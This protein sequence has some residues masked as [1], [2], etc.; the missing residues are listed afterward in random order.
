M[1]EFRPFTAIPLYSWEAPYE[2]YEYQ[3][4]KIPG[5]YN[6]RFRMIKPNGWS[7]SLPTDKFP[8]IIFFHGSGENG[9]ADPDL[10]NNS[11]QLQHGGQ[12]HM[13]AVLNGTFPGFVIYPQMRRTGT[14][15]G[16]ADSYANCPNNNWNPEWREAVRYVVDKLI[17]DYKVDPNRIYVHGL[18]G[19]GEASWQFITDYPEYIA[20]GHPMSAAGDE[21]HTQVYSGY[22]EY[23]KHIPLW[24]SQGALDTN[25]TPE[26]GNSQVTAIRNIGGSIRYS[27]YPTLGHGTWNSEYAKPDFFSWFLSKKKNQISVFYEQPLTCPG[28]PVSVRIGFT[29]T[30]YPNGRGNTLGTGNYGFG[31]VGNRMAITNYEWA[32]GNTNT[33]VATGAALNE[34]TITTAGPY[35]PGTYYGR[36]QRTDGTWTEW[37]DPVV[38]DNSRGPSSIPA[39]TANGKSINLPSLDGSADVILSGPIGKAAYQWKKGGANVS[40]ATDLNFTASVADSYTLIAK[41]A[42][43]NPYQFDAVPTEY[44]PSTTGCFSTDS[45]PISITTSNGLGVPSPPGNFFVSP[46]SQTNILV[47]W[48]D[49]SNNETGFE[50]Y[51]STSVG[52]GYSLVTI[53]PGGASS[54]P[55]IYSDVNIQANTT[56]YY[57]V[58]AVNTSGGSAY[59]SVSSAR[60]TVDTSSPTAPVLTIGGTLRTTALLQWTGATDNVAITAYDIYQN[61]SL[62]ASVNGN[63]TY[64]AANNLGA[65]S[66]YNFVVKARDLAGNESPP[67]N[68]VATIARNSGL[69]YK[70]YIHNNFSTSGEIASNGTLTKIGFISSFSVSQRTQSDKYAFIYEGF[71]NIPTT[72]DY[73]F[74]LQTDEGSKMWIN[75]VLVV[76]HDGQ[77]T[78]TKKASSVINLSAGWYPIRVDYF[79]NAGAECLTVRWTRPGQSEQTIPSSAFTETAASLPAVSNPSNLLSTSIA[80]N[81]VTLGWNDNSS[82]ETG[83]EIYRL[84]S[85]D[86][87]G[88]Y[89][90]V[91]SVPSATTSWIDNNVEANTRYY[92]RVR[93]ISE[94]NASSLVNLNS[95]G[96]V[97]TSAAPTPPVMPT[98]LSASVFSTTQIDLTW[99]DVTS[100]AGYEI[101]KSYNSTNGFV[102][103]ATVSANISSYSDVQANGNSTAYYQVRSLGAGGT[104]SAYSEIASAS[105]T[106]RSPVFVAIPDQTL[107]QNNASAQIINITVSDPD[108]DPISF[109]FTGLPSSNS[110]TSNGYGKGTLSLTSVLPGTYNIQVQA[111]DGIATVT[112]NFVLTVNSNRAPNIS[113][114]TIDGTAV[115]PTPITT[116]QNQSTEAGRKLTMV[117]TILDP[118][119]NAQLT[120]APLVTNLPSFATTVW[121]GTGTANRTF[122]VTFNTTAANVGIYD[123]LSITFRDNSG[124]I[125]VQTFSLVVTPFDPHYTVALNFIIATTDNEV[126]PWNNTPL[127]PATAVNMINLKDELGNTVKY[128]KFNIPGNWSTP[129]KRAILP[130]DPLSI[131][132]KKVR[133]SYYIKNTGSGGADSRTFK[134]TNLNPALKYKVTGYSAIPGTVGNTRYARFTITG[135]E[136]PAGPDVAQILPDLNV[137]N[138]TSATRTSDFRYPTTAG[139]LLV[140]VRG[141]QANSFF[142]I[143]ALILE[144]SYIEQSPPNTPSNVALQAPLNNKVNITWQDNSL[145]ETNFKIYRALTAAG[146]YTEVA[147]VGENTTGY[148]DVTTIGR[149]T[150]YY[151][152][153]AFNT[154]GESALS[155]SA[156]ITTPNGTPVLANPGTVILNVGQVVQTN[157]SATDPEGDPISFSVLNLPSFATLVDNGNGTG[158]IQF[159]AGLSNVGPYI[160]TLKVNDSYTA[161]AEAEFSLV[162]ADPEINEAVYI[163]FVSTSTVNAAAPWNNKSLTSDGALVNNVGVASPMIFA[164]SATANWASADN[165][166]VTTGTNAAIYPDRVLQS[167]WTTS[168]TVNTTNTITLSGLDNAKRYNITILGSRNEFWFANTIYRVNTGVPSGAEITLNTRKNSSALARFVGIQPSS[169]TIVISVRKDP[170]NYNPSPV[171]PA[172]D[173]FNRDGSINAMVVEA[174]TPVVPRRPSSLVAGGLSKSSIRLTWND[175]SSNETG[176]EVQ[177]AND[178][179]GPFATITTLAANITTWDDIGLPQ[180]KAYAYR[181]RSIKTSAPAAQSEYTNAAITST[182]DKIVLI[183]INS[184]TIE[185]HP[186]ETSGLWNNLNTSPGSMNTA[187]GYTWYNFIENTPAPTPIGMHEIYYGNGGSTV[188]GYVGT[189]PIYPSEVI[190]PAFLFLPND[191]PSEWV[192]QHLDPNSAYDMLFFSSDWDRTREG[193]KIV[194]DFTVGGSSQSLFN[195]R[196][197]SERVFFYGV[198]PEQD[199]TIYFQV[200][201]NTSEVIYNGLW[202]AFEIRSFTPLSAAFDNIAP[203]TPLNLTASNVASDSLRLTWTASSDNLGVTGYEIFRDGSLVSTVATTTARITGL[204]ASTTYNFTVRARD[205]KGNRSAFSNILPV[206]TSGGSGARQAGEIATNE[207]A[208]KDEYAD[209]DKAVQLYPNP[210]SGKLHILIPSELHSENSVVVYLINA[211]GQQVGKVTKTLENNVVEMNVHDLQSGLYNVMI[212]LTSGKIQKRFVKE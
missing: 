154:Y 13:N 44:R 70:Y 115:T 30:I 191:P 1:P 209:L 52:S 156:L 125:N 196:N 10:Q 37:S 174:Y 38:I 107:F 22:K 93:A 21:F 119:G 193:N 184:T 16:P 57:R 211:Q 171:A 65:L 74:S 12:T 41:D 82:N 8:L 15:C 135:K 116:V 142:Y 152:V 79:E 91:A 194:T 180:N 117:F 89:Q 144:A 114:L 182:F 56:Y 151:K 3:N 106:N 208:Q 148:S 173:I 204:H 58:R 161:S 195:G 109:Q 33:V 137:I 201:A 83:F 98:P 127:K 35:T 149:K 87:T 178:P 24:S 162:V 165:V 51:R 146:P 179:A 92:Y 42:A 159:N 47:N 124:G 99:A 122:T 121:A 97:V 168:Q 54:N 6:L 104:A 185:G 85:A 80:Y 43:G 48:D 187:E 96:Y 9:G 78:C 145:N 77:H 210:V 197:N 158:Y 34:I 90:V 108:I 172:I 143:N 11:R 110:F 69:L 53:V 118:N 102:T 164:H 147:T 72:G 177:R 101:Q 50:I 190:R 4:P 198:R 19:G 123:D 129:P 49:R 105:T 140:N 5:I 133:E 86:G 94:S 76:D 23:Y 169:G 71:I 63:A 39:I 212:P 60:T 153:S 73:T 141:T 67:S 167:G 157:I 150:Y 111:S 176:F 81:Q 46:V 36:F 7:S 131:Y 61:G 138:N 163:N 170:T 186:Q 27:Y 207:T 88:T 95:P 20:A 112:D 189:N 136:T 100:E 17:L 175:N 128:L 31:A 29:K 28:D 205:L 18:S 68:Q 132:T 25:P 181:V 199:S 134:F 64:Y 26:Q 45:S 160:V 55:L 155:E 14:D 139:E 126:A 120:Q 103:I 206:T 183:N 40:S 202:N 203:T 62:I 84:K 113:A 188:R 2:S 66:T 32:K 59:T 192:L 75:N 130:A 166:G 200:K